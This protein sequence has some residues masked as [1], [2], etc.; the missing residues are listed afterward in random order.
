MK[1]PKDKRT[2]EYKIWKETYGLGDLVND[3]TEKTGIKKI[4]G[5]CAPCSE[6]KKKWNEIALFKRQ[7]VVRCLNEEQL[8][9]YRY[10]KQSRK[11]K[12][13]NVKEIHLLTDLYAHAFAIQHK[14]SSFCANCSGSGKRLQEIENKL[15]KLIEQQRE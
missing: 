3:I 12:T 14:P 15:D 1:E 2:K 13:W 9:S 4:V 8:E 6:R 5:E 11:L 10:F 7:K